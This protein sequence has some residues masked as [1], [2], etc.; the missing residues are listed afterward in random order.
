MPE[1]RVTYQLRIERLEYRELTPEERVHSIRERDRYSPASSF[2]QP[3]IEL[4]RVVSVGTVLSAEL[5]EKEFQEIRTH[6]LEA[7]KRELT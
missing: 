7:W 3:A 5:T 1:L 6:T 2:E 4:Y